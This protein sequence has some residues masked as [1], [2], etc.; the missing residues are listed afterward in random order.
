MRNL[1]KKIYVKPFP[2]AA[3]GAAVGVGEGGGGA[4]AATATAAAGVAAT[5]GTAAAVGST[6]AA[7]AVSGAASSWNL[8]A[9]GA[10]AAGSD[11]S[12]VAAFTPT[13]RKGAAQLFKV[14]PDSSLVEIPPSNSGK[15]VKTRWGLVGFGGGE[16]VGMC[17]VGDRGGF[18]LRKYVRRKRARRK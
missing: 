2:D 1:Q 12:G 4:A 14:T 6:S 5:T 8:G 7:P 15:K 13:I 17:V 3:G 16:L 10:V 9:E 18:Y 11:G